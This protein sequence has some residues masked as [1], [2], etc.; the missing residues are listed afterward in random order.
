VSQPRA[1]RRTLTRGSAVD[2]AISAKVMAEN[3]ATAR[4]AKASNNAVVAPVQG[5]ALP[6]APAELIVVTLVLNPFSVIADIN[7]HCSSNANKEEAVNRLRH[8]CFW[9]HC[10]TRT[11]F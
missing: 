7:G 8:Y 9:R 10:V 3:S 2:P 6:L 1:K 11:P 5:G 4:T